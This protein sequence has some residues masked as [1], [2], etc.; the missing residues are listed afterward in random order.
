MDGIK[1]MRKA[2]VVLAMLLFAVGIWVRY[3]T[4][5]NAAQDIFQLMMVAT[6]VVGIINWRYLRREERGNSHGSPPD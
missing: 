4:D 2:A 3:G 5:W 6:M 1:T